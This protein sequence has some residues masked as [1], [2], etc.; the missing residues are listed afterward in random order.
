MFKYKDKFEFIFKKIL[1]NQLI[2]SNLNNFNINYIIYNN[3][4]NLIKNQKNDMIIYN[5]IYY[6]LLIIIDILNLVFFK[7]NKIVFINSNIFYQNFFYNKLKNT[8]Q[9]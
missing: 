6:L 9:Y 8:T 2:Y 3:Y 5:K 4:L 1:N 7:N